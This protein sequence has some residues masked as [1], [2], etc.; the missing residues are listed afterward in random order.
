[1]AFKTR[2]QNRYAVL[3]RSGFA[4]FESHTLSKVP[5]SIPYMESIIKDRTR[6]FKK[7]IQAEWTQGEWDKYITKR[8]KG[9]SWLDSKGKMTAWAMLRDYEG[10][11]RAKFP[12]YDSPWQKARG[13]MRDFVRTFEKKMAQLPPLR[14]MSEATK[15]KMESDRKQQEDHFRHIRRSE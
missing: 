12:T 5:F 1:M 10:R 7:A 8:Y 14:P 13:Q 4:K 3:R 15:A 9:N 11:Y 6:E 2:R